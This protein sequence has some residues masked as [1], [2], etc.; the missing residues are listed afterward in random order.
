MVKNNRLFQ[1]ILHDFKN[2]ENEKDLKK[3]GLSLSDY[4]YIY[5][6]LSIL[7]DLKSSAQ[8]INK[9]AADYFKKYGFNVVNTGIGFLISF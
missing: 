7:C 1:K 4:N 8:T 9:N 6:I 5:D 2:I 3:R